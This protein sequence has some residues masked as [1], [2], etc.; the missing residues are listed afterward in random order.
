MTSARS[1]TSKERLPKPPLFKPKRSKVA[2]AEEL[3]QAQ[4][5]A[6][7]SVPVS[8]SCTWYNGAPDFPERGGECGRT[9]VVADWYSGRKRVSCLCETHDRKAARFHARH[10]DPAIRRVPR[11]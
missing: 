2:T 3:A 6:D 10:D 1:R 5:I 4:A 9:P 7:Q 11:W 8:E